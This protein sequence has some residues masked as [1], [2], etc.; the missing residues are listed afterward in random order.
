MNGRELLRNP[1]HSGIFEIAHGYQEMVERPA[2]A[3]DR[4]LENKMTPR[5]LDDV[6]QVSRRVGKHL[7]PRIRMRMKI[8]A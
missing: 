1:A 3:R 8:E 2:T 4:I 6:G 5:A 7:Q